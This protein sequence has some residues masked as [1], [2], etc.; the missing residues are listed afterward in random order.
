MDKWLESIF[1]FSQG[2]NASPINLFNFSS[3]PPETRNPV[4]YNIPASGKRPKIVFRQVRL[5]CLPYLDFIHEHGVA[6][7]I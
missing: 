1:A 7:Y 4:L 6:K 2:F 3:G 5:L